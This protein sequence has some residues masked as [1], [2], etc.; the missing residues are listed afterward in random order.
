ML[1]V[2]TQLLH[3]NNCISCYF[4]A[5]ITFSSFNVNEALHFWYSFSA[6]SVM[7]DMALYSISVLA[8]AFGEWNAAYKDQI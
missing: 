6:V 5:F 3:Q 8:V 4:C 2:S 1:N 7:T